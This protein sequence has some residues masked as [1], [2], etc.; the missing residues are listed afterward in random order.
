MRTI[1]PIVA[2]LLCACGAA[3]ESTD[4]EGVTPRRELSTPGALVK[5]TLV[6]AQMWM[7][8]GYEVPQVVIGAQ[9]PEWRITLQLGV[10]R[11]CNT[12][13]ALGCTEMPIMPNDATLIRISTEVPEDQLVSVIAHELGHALGFDDLAGGVMD[14]QRDLSGPVCVPDGACVGQN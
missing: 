12:E 10:I 8:A 6:A 1:F 5:P 7:D 4:P 3:A 11:G 14:S 13:A 9:H 2:L